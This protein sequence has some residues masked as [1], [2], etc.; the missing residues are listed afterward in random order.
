MKGLNEYLLMG[1]DG[2]F[3]WSSYLVAIVLLAGTA[4]VI[5]MRNQRLKRQS[6]AAELNVGVRREIS[7]TNDEA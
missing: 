3:I 2:I 5:L 4:G 7:D 6:V 1:G